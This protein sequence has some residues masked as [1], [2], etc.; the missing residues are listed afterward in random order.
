MYFK[1]VEY[2]DLINRLFYLLELDVSSLS[3]LG[4]HDL[5]STRTNDVSLYQ[6]RSFSFCRAQR[7]ASERLHRLDELKA[8]IDQI[9]SEDGIK[10]YINLREEIVSS[11]SIELPK[12]KIKDISKQDKQEHNRRAS[13][14]LMNFVKG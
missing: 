8:V 11:H 9:S 10:S 4:G 1:P 6:L 14:G 3:G 2:E 13:Q 7:I 12:E 5:E